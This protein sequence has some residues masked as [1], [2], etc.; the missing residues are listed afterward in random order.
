MNRSRYL[1]MFVFVFAILLSL[2]YPIYVR[3]HLLETLP[4]IVSP[5]HLSEVLLKSIAV[6]NLLIFNNLLVILF[7]ISIFYIYLLGRFSIGERLFFKRNQVNPNS[8]KNFQ[9]EK[10]YDTTRRFLGNDWFV[11]IYRAM[12]NENLVP[13][14]SSLTFVSPAANKGVYE[15]FLYDYLKQEG[16]PIKFAIADIDEIENH[17]V[18]NIND[19][20]LRFFPGKEALRIGDYLLEIGETKTDV[21]FDIKGSLWYSFRSDIDQV[22]LL[23]TFYSV[24]NDDGIIIIDNSKKRFLSF[25]I[26]YLFGYVSWYVET[27]TGFLLNNNKKKNKKF[28]AYM[29]SHFEQKELS[30]QNDFKDVFN[31]ILLKKKP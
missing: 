15:K 19:E 18:K 6:N 4:N 23:E 9:L 3:T 14:K 26:Y 28:K 13:Q 29:D 5:K 7:P 8:K 27:S 1:R 21:I 17:A 20:N 24:L 30:F 22:K 25:C 31:V 10:W 16:I 2:F 12:K 11:H